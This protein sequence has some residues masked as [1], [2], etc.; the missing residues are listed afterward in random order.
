M[1]NQKNGLTWN[2]L[3]LNGS[4]VHLHT[5]RWMARTKLKPADLGIED[6]DAV[7]TALSLGAHRLAPTDA[8]K[9][10][11]EARA[12]ARRH[13]DHYSLNFG[14]VFGARYVPS[15]NMEELS[16]KLQETA[17]QFS[18]AVEDFIE[19]YETMKNEMLP[20]IREALSDA[21]KT[22]DAADAAYERVL[23]EYPPK[24]MIRS[25]FGIRW[26]VYA[27]QGPKQQGV[28]ASMQSEGETVKG[29]VREMME[30]LRGEVAEKLT[31]ILAII[32]KGG[33]LNSLSLKAANAT[34][35]H[36][37]RVNIMGDVELTD[38]C[39]KLRRVLVGMEN[40]GRV[41]DEEVK[42][43]NDIQTALQ[44]NLDTAVK[45]AE[46]KLTG[47]GRRKLAVA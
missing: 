21:A 34:I 25:K 45:D 35:D 17:E 10:I 22:E 20:V 40:G 12:K 5:S 37:E 46:T 14:F 2:D 30:Q 47:V 16:G 31:K 32:N 7:A 41:S 6:S 44:G 26:D 13:V 3:F 29:A 28:G 9:Q 42:G 8:F 15:T 38:Q 33:K 43:L 39:N 36:I 24:E 23:Q 27:I 11:D 19:N 1:E 18:Q 4:V